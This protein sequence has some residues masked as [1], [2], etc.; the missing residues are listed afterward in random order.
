[1]Y[2]QINSKIILEKHDRKLKKYD[3]N[4]KVDRA[5]IISKN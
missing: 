2:A 5:K 4:S 1:M 3:K